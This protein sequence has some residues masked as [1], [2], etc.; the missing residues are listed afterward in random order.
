MMRTH[1]SAL[2]KL[3]SRKVLV[4]S[5]CAIIDAARE[6]PPSG[7]VYDIELHGRF[8]DHLMPHN[9]LR[10]IHAPEIASAFTSP[11]LY[12]VWLWEQGSARLGTLAMG[13]DR[14]E[15]FHERPDHRR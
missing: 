6:E 12:D 1:I 13:F 4:I 10:A 14:R 11:Q 3:S 2:A 5:D 9:M 7:S 8:F 15:R